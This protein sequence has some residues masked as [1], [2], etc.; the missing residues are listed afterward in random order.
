[1]ARI[2]PIRRLMQTPLPTISEQK[3]K[4]YRPNRRQVCEIYDLINHYVFKNNLRRPPIHLGPWKNVW[5]MCIGNLTS[6]R[7]GTRCSIK[8]VDRY[9]CVQWFVVTIAHEMVHQ[10]EWDILDKDMTHRQSF[11]YWKDKLLNY[12]IP[13][14]SYHNSVNWFHYQNIYKS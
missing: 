3:R 12:D 13:L 10:Y 7:P 2:N 8:L 4:P 1:M 14:K 6:V 9:Y 5:G 11:F